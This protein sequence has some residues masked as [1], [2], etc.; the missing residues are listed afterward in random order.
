MG[1]I[2]DLL[3]GLDLSAFTSED[4]TEETATPGTLADEPGD[5]SPREE[6]SAISVVSRAEG[7]P[8][9]PEEVAME[10][11]LAE[12]GLEPSAAR[13]DLT[14]RGD[15]DLDDLQ[16]YSIVAVV[17]RALKKSFPDESIAA[18]QTVGDF[19]DAVRH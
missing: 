15:L 6:E 7:E 4:D 14:L 11:L 9:S 10:A 17:E 5:E 3:G 8:A 1:T 18:W 19:L 12:T 16:L 13:A 2:G